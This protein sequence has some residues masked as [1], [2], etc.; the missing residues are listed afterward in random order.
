MMPAILESCGLERAEP[1][2]LTIQINSTRKNGRD[3]WFTSYLLFLAHMFVFGLSGFMMAY[4]FD[5]PQIGFMYMHGGLAILVYLLFYLAMFGVDEV[6]WMFINSGLGLMGI[7]SEIDMIL[8]TVFG[9]QFEDYPVAV[10]VIPFLYYILYTF[11]LR[12]FFIDLARARDKPKRKRFMEA[13]YVVLSL[14][15]YGWLW[16]KG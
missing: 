9:K 13:L 2:D 16:T 14:V 3:Y 8:S 10:H 12:Q 11:L 4:A 6:K 7:L 1:R 5:P 15:V